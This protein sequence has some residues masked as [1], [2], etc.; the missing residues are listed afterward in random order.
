MIEHSI[1]TEKFRPKTISEYVFTDDSQKNQINKWIKDQ[2][3]PHILLWGGPGTG[4]SSLAKLLL[5]ELNIDPFD[6]LELN[7]SRD[8]SVDE[9]RAKITNFVS[10]MPFGKYKI[11]ILDEC[12]DEGTLVTILRGGQEIKL[13]IKDLNDSLDL[14]KTFNLEKNRFE[15]QTFDLIDK[16][17]QE[18]L[19]IS[20]EDG[21]VVICTP[22]HKWFVLDDET[23]QPKVVN[24]SELA[25]Y[26]QIL[27]P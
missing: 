19:E 17:I 23:G 13:P 14:V 5:N 20:F 12:L 1:W 7:A 18:V 9:V 24:A 6:V 22:T 3:C 26:N 11:V 25:L 15:Y 27:T 21:S 2:I 4:K 8:N 10:C 16:S